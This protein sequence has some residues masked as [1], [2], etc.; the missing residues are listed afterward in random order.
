MGKFGIINS[1]SNPEEWYCKNVEVI[2]SDQQ[3]ISIN[4]ICNSMK[5]SK[6]VLNPISADCRVRRVVIRHHV[7]TYSWKK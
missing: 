5:I 3:N 1:R 4:A 2:S 7:G 6:D